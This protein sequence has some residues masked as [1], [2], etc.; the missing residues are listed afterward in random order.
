[1]TWSGAAFFAIAD[2]RIK[3]IWV[4]GDI[5]SIRQQ[6]GAPRDASFTEA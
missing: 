4:L 3:D 6:L 1:V 2:Q 5:D